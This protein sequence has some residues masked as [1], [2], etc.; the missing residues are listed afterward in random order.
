MLQLLASGLQF[1][2]RQRCHVEGSLELRLHGSAFNLLRGRLDGVSL[3]ARRVTYQ[4]LE[5]ELVDLRSSAIRVQM[6]NLLRGQALQLDQPFAIQGQLSFSPDG[7]SRSFTKARWRG[8]ADWLAEHLLGIAPLL[9]LGIAGNR[10][11]LKAQGIGPSDRVELEIC[12]ATVPG[13]LSFTTVDG[14]TELLVLPLDASIDLRDARIE[15]G[16][17]VLDGSAQVT[18]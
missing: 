15:A 14:S 10:L 13:G 8:L 6:G 16:M 3:H 2:L 1:W 18:P 11:A 7:L 12:L 17:V 9:D 5:I 4:D